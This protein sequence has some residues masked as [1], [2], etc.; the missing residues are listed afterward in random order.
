MDLIYVALGA[1]LWLAALGLV[2]GCERL[3]QRTPQPQSP[4]PP[5]HQVPR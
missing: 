5:P 2:R 3:H 4:P 1:T